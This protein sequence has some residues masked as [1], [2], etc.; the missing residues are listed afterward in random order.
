MAM[1]LLHF[2]L[3]KDKNNRKCFDI[4]HEEFFEVFVSFDEVGN[5]TQH[6]ASSLST[7]HKQ[8]T[9]LDFGWF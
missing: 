2:R 5:P 9:V 6:Y 4:I 8:Y 1:V 7:V 3:R